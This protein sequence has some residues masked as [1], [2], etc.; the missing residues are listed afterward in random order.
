ML[1]G[2]TFKVQ[3]TPETDFKTVNYRTKIEMSQEGF[4][5]LVGGADD[6]K[7]VYWTT[8]I[9]TELPIKMG[10]EGISANLKPETLP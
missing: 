1:M 8:D 3:R 6:G 4:Q 5:K 2:D 10:N 7:N 9:T